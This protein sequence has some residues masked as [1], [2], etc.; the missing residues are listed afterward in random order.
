MSSER[1]EGM[2]ALGERYIENNQ[3]AGMVNL[4]MRNGKVVHYAAHG[5]KGADDNRP[6]QKDD[7]F[8]IY[9]MTKPITAVAL[10]QLYE[11]GKF[12]LNDPVSKFVPELKGVKVLNAVGEL[13]D[14]KT[15]MTIAPVINSYSWPFIRVR[16]RS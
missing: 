3:V 10:M 9:S 11:Q 1:L 2:I 12:L 13:E 7:L 4:V 14:Q 8:R 16:S 6:L 15:P 5:K